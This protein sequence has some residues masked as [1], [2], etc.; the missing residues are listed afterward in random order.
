MGLPQR[1]RLQDLD[2]YRRPKQKMGSP[3]GLAKQQVIKKHGLVSYRL[4]DAWN[5]FPDRGMGLPFEKVLGWQENAS[6]KTPGSTKSRQRPLKD[7]AQDVG[8]LG[9]SGIRFVGEAD[10]IIKRVSLDWGSPGAIELLTRGL[11]YGTDALS[12]AK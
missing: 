5:D 2:A 6:H 10:K 3:P 7:L 1:R 4:H 12:L 9:K 8:K 11:T